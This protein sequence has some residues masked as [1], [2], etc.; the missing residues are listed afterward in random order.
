MFVWDSI[1]NYFFTSELGY[2]EFAASVLILVN[3]YLLAR[4]NIWNFLWGA[5]GV[6]LFGYIFYQSH[7]YADMLLQWG[8][9]LP[10]SV[11]GWWYWYYM[12]PSKNNLPLSVGTWSQWLQGIGVIV[13]GTAAAGF[14]FDNFTEAH[15]PYPDSFILVTSLVAT[16]LLNKKVVENWFLWVLVDI[17]AVPT[18]FLKELYVTSGLYVIL[19]CLASY[20]L[21]S[22]I[23]TWAQQNTVVKWGRDV[24]QEEN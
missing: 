4:Q 13:L 5:I 1:R 23:I 18:Y 20:G 9:Y 22:W 7:L 14:Y 15:Y 16:F 12:G 24:Q 10:M 2:I 8:Y 11:V 3:V 21:I 19:F 6:A 17:V